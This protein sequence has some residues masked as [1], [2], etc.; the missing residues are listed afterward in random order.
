MSFLIIGSAGYIGSHT[1]RYLQEND[2]NV[3]VVDNL[4]KGHKESID[5][6]CF[7]QIDILDKSAL[8]K[9]FK[10]HQINAVIHFAANS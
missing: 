7:Y 4:L 1:V 9:V 8:D 10:Q 5:V 2:E 3:I 6:D